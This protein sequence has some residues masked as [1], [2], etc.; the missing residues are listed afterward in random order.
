MRSDRTRRLAP[1]AVLVLALA[2]AVLVWD[3]RGAGRSGATSTE[4]LWDE[5][6]VAHVF[7]GSDAELF[8]GQGWAQAEAHGDLLLEL[9]GRARAR[10]AEYWGETWLASDRWLSTNG[11]PERAARWYAAQKP[12][13]KALLDAFARGINDYARAHPEAIADRVEPVLPVTPADVL[14]HVQA[15]LHFTFVIDR[16]RVDG[17]A[18][19]LSAGS[20]AWAVA[21]SR[22]A[23]GK[24]MLVA[25]PHLPWDDLFTWFES[26]LVSPGIDA[27][28]ASLVGTPFLGIA[29]N[30]HLGWTH[31]VNTHDGADLYQLTLAGEGDGEGYRYDGE[32]RAFERE[33]KTLKVRQ[34]DGSLKEEKLEVRRSVH[35]PVVASAG[36]KAL[37]LRVVGLEEPH[38]V[39]QYW[40][41]VAAKD[42]AGFEA[43]L[44]ELQ[45]PMFTV[46]YADDAGHVL[47][48]F[49]GRTPVRPAGDW[50]WSGTVPGD[51]SKTLWTATHPYAELPR[52]LDPPSG[53]L[54]NANDP[55][56]TTTFP[57]A[58]DP[59]RFPRY[60]APHS[61]SFRAQR[62]ARMLEEDEKITF[63]ELTAYK[64]STRME[65]A[66]R[67]LDDLARAVEAQGDERAKRAM[68][69]LSA[70]D[71]SADAG[72]RGAVL[73]QHFWRALTGGGKRPFATP[74]NEAQ[75]TSTPDGLADPAA[76]AAALSTAAAEVEAEHGALDVAWGDVHRLRL[77][78]RD[79]P[80]NGGPGGLGI[81]RVTEYDEAAGHREVAESGDSYVAL[82]EFSRPVRARVLLSYGNWSQPGSRHHGDQL[83]L[84]SSKELRPAWRTRAEIE[85]HLERRE[86]L[87]P[88]IAMMPPAP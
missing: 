77:D 35:G 80:A 22:S 26:Q 58:L 3:A 8:Y 60:M 23:S 13:E 19:R 42:L 46:V 48:L 18:R 25:N 70:W 6:G 74:W 10:G 9:Y 32:V 59:G 29:F 17:A 50:D 57:P 5:W 14:A 73:F 36:G 54:Q 83:A 65:L 86:A 67:I 61:M 64:L 63:D 56:W 7:A 45:M 69:V 85:A 51:T 20:N 15:V 24:A 75:P 82:V 43:A 28:G 68:A 16:G 41:M 31:T 1:V 40:R 21:P 33:T 49:G 76:A 27:Y 81:F 11:V 12:H 44:A 88:G 71:R 2:A 62:S 78:G 30:D 47:H 72:S 84:F 4:I 79:L 53:W 37:A 55:P 66:D 39:D 38:I 34:A 87:E 52:V